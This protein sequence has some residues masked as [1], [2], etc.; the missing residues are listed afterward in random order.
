MRGPAL[1]PAPAPDPTPT[2]PREPTPGVRPVSYQPSS[3]GYAE[4]QRT[5]PVQ[6]S[7]PETRRE[8][9]KKTVAV[10]RPP[11][12]PATVPAKE[13]PKRWFSRETPMQGDILTPPFPEDK[14][15]EGRGRQSALFPQAIWETPAD[16][17][18]VLYADQVVQGL[19][20]QSLQ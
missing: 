12:P 18:K 14:D 5:E 6:T 16:P 7:T 4:P 3:H 15:A 20:M 10:Q 1:P 11:A 19:L 9:V 2:V 8:D 17:T 13:A